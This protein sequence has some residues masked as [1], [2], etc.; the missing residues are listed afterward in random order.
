LSTLGCAHCVKLL[1]S[2]SDIDGLVAH[3][4]LPHICRPDS[5]ERTD[6]ILPQPHTQLQSYIYA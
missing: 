5:G 1:R 3:D 6:N 4:R 2:A